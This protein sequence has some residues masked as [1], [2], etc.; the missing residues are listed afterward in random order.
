MT[1]ATR[2]DLEARFGADE[3]ED[4][5]PAPEEGQPDLSIQAAVADAAAVIDG[6]L[7]RAY[8]LPL[9]SGSPWPVLTSIAT[10]LA[11]Q[12]LYGEEA[13]KAVSERARRARALLDGIAAGAVDLVN[14][15]G[16]IALRRQQGAKY[17]GRD[18]E[19]A[20]SDPASGKLSG[21]DAF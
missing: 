19:F 17:V 16:T 11:R 7:A 21:L 8:D 13:P 4:L 6:V 15:G 14:A 5:A 12:R 3:I 2:A 10:D 20:G 18:R 1:Y 9:Q